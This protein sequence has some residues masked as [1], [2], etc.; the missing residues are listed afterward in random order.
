MTTR[1]TGTI[2][3]MFTDIEGSTR[4]VQQLGTDRWSGLLERHRELI[5]DAISRHGGVEV[6]TE[7]DGFFAAFPLPAEAVGAAVDAQRGLASEPWPEEAPVRVRIGLHTGAGRLDADGTY[8]GAD[9]HRAARIAAAGHGEQV[10]ISEATRILSGSELPGGVQL[11]DLGQAR[12]KDLDQPEQLYQLVVEGLRSDFPPLRTLGGTPTNL[13]TEVTTFL[14]RQQ[15]IADIVALVGQTRLLTL[16]GPGGTGKTRLALQVAARSMADF[17][18]GVWFV[19]LGSISESDLVAPTI[20]HEVGLPNRGGRNPLEQLLEHFRGKRSL[21]VLDNFEQVQPA[22]S[23][24]S[25]LVAACSDLAIL[26]TSRSALH[27]YGER[28]YPVPPLGVPDPAHLPDLVSLSQYEAVA[29]FVERSRAVKPGFSV[30]NDNAPAVAEI[31]YR[32]D[33]LPLAL[34]LAAARIKLLSPQAI[35][36]RFNDR[37]DLL[38]AARDLPA[39]QQTLRGAIGWSYDMLDQD[40]RALFGCFS[41]FIGGA[42]IEAAE[43][44]CGPAIPGADVLDLLASLVD[45]SL[46]RQADTPSGEPRFSMLNTI[47]EYAAERLAE[48]GDAPAAQGRH[49]D[50]FLAMVDSEAGH[51]MDAD[52]GRHL[53][54]LEQEHDNLRAAIAWATDNGR[55]E[56]AL[57]L[58]AGLWRFWQMRGY[59][60]EGRERLDRALALPAASDQ[61]DAKLAALEA[62]GGI[63]YWQGDGPGAQR[64]YQAT[65]ELARA[66]GE[67]AAEANAQYN[68]SF[69]FMYSPDGRKAEE[70]ALLARAHAFEALEIYR[71]IG[72]RAGEARTMWALSNVAWSSAQFTDEAVEFAKQSLAAFRELDDQFQIGWASYTV[73]LFDLSNRRLEDAARGLTE[74]LEI[75][76]RAGDVSGYVLVIDAVALLAS[77][78][79]DLAEAARL[80]GAVAE[81]ERRT[82]TGLNPLNREVMS[83]DPET[84]RD[85]P[86]TA[87]AWNVG[88]TLAPSEAVD[89]AREFLARVKAGSDPTP[90]E[91]VATT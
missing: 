10:V 46:I 56:T 4:L 68:L 72:D 79:G 43:A 6:G 49:A 47:R 22:A 12:L 14:G 66:S 78:T 86:Q 28:E 18:D 60:S 81:L 88:T 2:T 30:T 15:E 45:K 16:T 23:V 62:A 25:E 64:L 8:V 50:W 13:P 36:A 39:R 37:L 9:V 65:L 69:A 61:A 20:A 51:L 29:L 48:E 85:N 58:G 17:Q 41:V 44:V 1:P 53:D 40:E 27:L 19:A 80:S 21:V 7:G 38:A 84:L 75:F 34:E 33:G 74:S 31:A 73:A 77:R 82:G 76:A 71:R 83:W 70:R 26:V 11:R 52:K 55:T 24:V 63:A 90:S 57:R 32:L 89:A 87:D 5:R 35:L 3:F 54:L 91:E 59:L 67:P 42:S